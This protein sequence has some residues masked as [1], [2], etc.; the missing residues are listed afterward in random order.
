MH[1][2]TKGLRLH[3]AVGSQVAMCQSHSRHM[4]L[5]TLCAA[6]PS[7]E[8][9]SVQ[10]DEEFEVD[11]AHEEELLK[12]KAAAMAAAVQ[13]K[14]KKGSISLQKPTHLTANEGSDRVDNDNLIHLLGVL[15][16][17]VRRSLAPCG[18]VP[19]GAVLWYCGHVV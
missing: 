7:L 11:R 19:C 16:G 17:L 13:S 15:C 18:A 10:R 14:P 5:H 1:G 9:S 6:I 12:A 8:F 2:G 4:L 3:N